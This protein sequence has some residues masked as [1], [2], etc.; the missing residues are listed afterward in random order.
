[1]KKTI[2]LAAIAAVAMVGCVKEN[3]NLNSGDVP[4]SL[5][6]SAMGIESRAVVNPNDAFTAQVIARTSAGANNVYTNPLFTQSVN[7]AASAAATTVTGQYYPANDALLYF[8]GYSPA[9]APD[10]GI[11][12]FTDITGQEDIMLSDEVSGKKT[13]VTAPNLTFGHLLTQINIKIVAENPAAIT[14]WGNVTSIDVLDQ[15][16]GFTL[17]VTSG[18]FTPTG[19][20]NNSFAVATA[21]T[22]IA[23]PD[24]SAPVSAVAVSY[25]R[26]VMFFPMAAL[27]TTPL[28]LLVKTTNHTA[29]QLVTLNTVTGGTALV[30]GTAYTVTLTFKA[31]EIKLSGTVTDWTPGTDTPVDIY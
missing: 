30:A 4:V 26:P 24:A 15:Y 8:K 2:F 31:T 11:A 20:A 7:F 29:G 27:G 18:T 9:V 3:T 5:T 19:S 28:N 21:A 13:S 10:S 14:A 25:G 17:D 23:L 1:M 22:N 6:G 16:N 12:T